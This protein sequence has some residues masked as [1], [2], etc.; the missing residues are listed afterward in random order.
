MSDVLG[1]CGHCHE[2]L[3]SPLACAGCERIFPLPK[4]LSPF[5][6]FGMEPVAHVDRGALRKQ[7]LKLQR[8]LH[9]DFHGQAG[10]GEQQLAEHNTAELNSAYEVLCDEAKRASFLI[11]HLGGP[12]ESKERQMPQVFLMEVM[13]WNEALEEMR[14][15]E[16]RAAAAQQAEELHGELKIERVRFI[17]ALLDDLHAALQPGATPDLVALRRQSNAIRYIDRA[18]SEAAQIRLLA[19]AT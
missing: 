15:A 17:D 2:V 1:D 3:T 7:L 9:P 16:D 8:L 6:V 13:E 10:E 11:E 12:S 14:N 5:E 18:L 19:Q 4:Q